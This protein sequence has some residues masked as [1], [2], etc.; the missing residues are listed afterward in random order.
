MARPDPR[1]EAFIA[2]HRFGFGPKPGEIDTIA[3]DPRGW[4]A[5]QVTKPQPLPA[6]MID[7]PPVSENVLDW[8]AAV[9]TSVAE[10]VKRIRGPYTRLWAREA[11]ARLHAAIVTDAPFHER[12]VWF[13]GDHFTC[14]GVKAVAIGM[15]GGHER[16][17]IRPHVS[18][19]FGDML[20]AASEHP[21]MLFYLDN[22]RSSGPDSP[23]GYYGR[24]GINENLAREILELHTLGV[25]QGYD[26]NDVQQFAKVLTGWTFAR[27]HEPNAGGFHFHPG[28]HERGPKTVLGETYPENGVEEGRAVLAR[29][30]THPSTAR[31]IATKLARHFVADDP[32]ATLV[33]KLAKRFLDTDGD[34]QQVSLAMIEADESWDAPLTKVKRPAEY[35]VAVRRALDDA[36]DIAAVMD[37]LNSLGN[38]PFMANSP[39]GWPDREDAWLTPDSAVRRARF[40]QASVNGRKANAPDAGKIAEQVLGDLLPPDDRAQLDNLPNDMALA[41][42]L[43]SPAFQRR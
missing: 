35:T 43:A 30:A 39:A 23:Q 41:L 38:L 1:I 15:A 17:A 32:P 40:A 3:Q 11:G 19:R 18:G 5:E 24:R 2:A 25:D 22:Y 20:L 34:L 9:T 27:A 14:S 29:L 26:Q 6:A 10:L 21:G 42:V 8:W 36:S 4:L 12:L 31:H 16:E 28:M 7:M 37:A 13:W 33:D